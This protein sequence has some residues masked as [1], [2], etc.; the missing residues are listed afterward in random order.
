MK[1][2]DGSVFFPSNAGGVV[3]DDGGVMLAFAY[4]FA[5]LLLCTCMDGRTDG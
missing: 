1:I 2:I 5:D 4:I 3:V